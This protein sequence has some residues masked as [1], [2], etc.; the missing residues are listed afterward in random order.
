[1]L[2]PDYNAVVSICRRRNEEEAAKMSFRQLP[3]LV[4]LL[5]LVVCECVGIT[6]TASV[7][8]GQSKDN[9]STSQ[10]RARKRDTLRKIAQRLGLPLE[11]LVRLNSLGADAALP[12]GM[13]IELPTSPA[14]AP[15]NANVVGKRITL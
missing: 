7:A 8:N 9:G 13:K 4:L 12:R 6:A 14:P 2:T 10:I 15:D 3:Q 1:M 5:C 11:E